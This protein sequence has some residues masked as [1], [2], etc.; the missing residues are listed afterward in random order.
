[1][2]PGFELRT[3][4]STFIRDVSTIEDALS[5]DNFS[6]LAYFEHMSSLQTWGGSLDIATV[7]EIGISDFVPGKKQSSFTFLGSYRCLCFGT[8]SKEI[9]LLYSGYCHYDCLVD[10]ERAAS[11]TVSLMNDFSSTN[12]ATHISN[13]DLSLEHSFLSIK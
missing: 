3:S 13:Y 8:G 12:L 5:I 4:I 6:C 10:C 9:C 11:C 1:M 2:P 7:A